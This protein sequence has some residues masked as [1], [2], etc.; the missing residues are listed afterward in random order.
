MKQSPLLVFETAAF[1]V[2]PGEDEQA[3]PG[4][5]GKSLALWL[6]EQLRLA[7]VSAGEVIAEDFGWCIPVEP[8]SHSLYV[9]CAGTGE[10]P[11][12][13]RVFA[14]A[15]S[16]VID[17]LRGKDKSAES[18]AALFAAVRRCIE[19]APDIRGLREELV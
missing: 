8:T 12:Q 18:L 6:A 7:G 1:A 2:I 16:R 9:A 3:N 10:E 17:R 4:V 15:E 14:F 5:V 19:A 13:W 11:D